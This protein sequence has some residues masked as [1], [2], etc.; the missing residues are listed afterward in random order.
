MKD[1]SYQVETVPSHAIS[2]Q[3][4]KCEA[5]KIVLYILGGN[6]QEAAGNES[7]HFEAPIQG[8]GAL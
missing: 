1:G 5:Q 2:S 3:T 8:Q 4:Y 6:K 7:A